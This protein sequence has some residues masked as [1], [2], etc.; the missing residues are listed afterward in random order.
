MRTAQGKCAAVVLLL[1]YAPDFTVEHA[2]AAL[3]EL[4][5]RW[6]QRPAEDA[7]PTIREAFRIALQVQP[8]VCKVL[9]TDAVVGDVDE[10]IKLY[11]LANAAQDTA[12]VNRAILLL[13][14]RAGKGQMLDGEPL[15]LVVADLLSRQGNH[16][17]AE[18]WFRRAHEEHPDDPRAALRLAARAEGGARFALLR[19]A[20]A[21]GERTHSFLRQ[22]AR[23]ASQQGEGL[24]ALAL[25]DELCAGEQFD[26]IDLENAV[27]RCIALE[28]LEWAQQRLGKHAEVVA[29]EPRL[30]RLDL[31]C[32]LSANGMSP[33]AKDLARA[34]R[35]S[36]AQDAFVE[37]LLQKFGG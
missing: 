15:A 1:R 34:W 26:A 19:E 32:E 23:E 16:N 14:Q 6:L 35:E 22:L 4:D 21:R 13:G 24:L 25:L 27:L 37:S 5:P 3:A 7:D 31:I 18:A 33:R 29:G 36:G 28:R 20:Y 10:A 12:H 9:T 30:Q 17:E 11:R 2:R 8:V